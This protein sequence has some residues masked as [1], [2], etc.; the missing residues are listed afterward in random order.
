MGQMKSYS[1]DIGFLSSAIF[2]LEKNETRNFYMLKF[3]IHLQI[4]DIIVTSSG[5]QVL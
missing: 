1:L 4:T 2:V 5:L 3:F